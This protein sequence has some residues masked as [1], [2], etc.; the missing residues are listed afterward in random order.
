MP[1]TC[2]IVATAAC[3]SSTRTAI[4][5]RAGEPPRMCH[6]IC[7]RIAKEG[8]GIPLKR[9]LD[10]LKKRVLYLRGF[11]QMGRDLA[12]GLSRL[13]R[14]GHD[15]A[16]GLGQLAGRVKVRGQ[17]TVCSRRL[18]PLAILSRAAQLHEAAIFGI[19]RTEINSPSLRLVQS[20]RL[21]KESAQI[22]QLRRSPPAHWRAYYAH[23]RPVPCAEEGTF[24]R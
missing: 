18:P 9:P 17:M 6:N 4:T 19:Q 20:D 23:F 21:R 8:R 24:S 15:L 2:L 7:V 12:G 5:R 10:R 11:A 14:T 13:P 16:D 22:F 1:I 3:E